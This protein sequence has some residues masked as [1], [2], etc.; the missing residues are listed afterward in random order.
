[1]TCNVLKLL[2]FH[3]LHALQ[4]GMCDP[5]PL[6]RWFCVLEVRCSIHF[7]FDQP[8]LLYV[9]GLLRDGEA[10]GRPNVASSLILQVQPLPLPPFVLHLRPA[11]ALSF[12][13]QF[14]V[15]LRSCA[16]LTFLRRCLLTFHPS[17]VDISLQQTLS[18]DIPMRLKLLWGNQ[19]LSPEVVL[20]EREEWGC[21]SWQRIGILQVEVL[22]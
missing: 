11:L 4:L 13:D 8:S 15:R 18:C 19:V 3:L 20:R 22:E 10:L 2:V 7:S 14:L 16:L 17:Q 5:F 1:M 21:I 12:D 6:E 9:S